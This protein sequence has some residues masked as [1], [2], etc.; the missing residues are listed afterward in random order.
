MKK[1][2][3]FIR[4]FIVILIIFISFSY[5]SLKREDF[6]SKETFAYN[7]PE[8]RLYLLDAFE[9]Y[10]KV[11]LRNNYNES[12]LII[13]NDSNE[14]NNSSLILNYST[15]SSLSYD[16]LDIIINDE[17][18]SLSDLYYKS[19]GNNYLFKIDD[20]E[21]KANN[22]IEYNIKLKINNT[23]LAS[24]VVDEYYYINYNLIH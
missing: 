21:I 2:F 5:W 17:L 11:G 14:K 12:N 24:E 19:N 9:S 15:L 20:F 13:V 4:I 8:I 22:Y 10:F 23:S 18:Y 1:Y 7:E 6:N 3:I 16:H